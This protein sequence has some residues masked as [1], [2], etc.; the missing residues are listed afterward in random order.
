MQPAK[1]MVRNDFK[2]SG[3]EKWRAVGL[4]S[5]FDA[6]LPRLGKLLKVR[7]AATTGEDSK[8]K[9][10]LSKE[11]LPALLKHIVGAASTELSGSGTGYG[12]HPSTAIVLLR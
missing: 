8:R 7:A 10:I 6:R 9:T 3:S 11:L 5:P 2:V 12:Y 4:Q 1:R